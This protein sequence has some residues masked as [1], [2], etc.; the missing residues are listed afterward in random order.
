MENKIDDIVGLTFLEK[1]EII[2]LNSRK[3]QLYFLNLISDYKLMYRIT[4]DKKYIDK[5]NKILNRKK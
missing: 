4:K 2:F 3:K 1:Q 5:I